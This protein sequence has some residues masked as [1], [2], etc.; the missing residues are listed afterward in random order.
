MADGGTI[1]FYSVEKIVEF[2]NSGGEGSA[3]IR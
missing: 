2:M 3:G 1:P